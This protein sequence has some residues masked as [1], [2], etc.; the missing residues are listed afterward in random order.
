M[1]HGTS[2]SD[3]DQFM[4]KQK[5]L[6]ELSEILKDK[7]LTLIQALL[8]YLWSTGSSTIPIPGAKNV[9]QIEENAKVL[10]LGPLKPDIIKLINTL[11][12]D[13]RSFV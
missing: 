5:K 12:E 2:F 13:V 11:F 6:E 7:D 3:S 8:S 4:N 1:L 9:D 10:E